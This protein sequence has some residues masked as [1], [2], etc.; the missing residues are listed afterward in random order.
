[1]PPAISDLLYKITHS[2]LVDGSPC[3]K[4][5]GFS[6]YRTKLVKEGGQCILYGKIN[7]KDP[8]SI[9]S[10][11]ANVE[12]LLWSNLMSSSVELPCQFADLS[13]RTTSEFCYNF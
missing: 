11:E 8:G 4:N 3:T 10:D 13:V 12:I 5:M 2:L 7:M 9:Q 6:Q 1:M